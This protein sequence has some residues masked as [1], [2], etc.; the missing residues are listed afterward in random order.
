MGSQR[1]DA[2]N[3]LLWNDSFYVFENK[4]MGVFESRTSRL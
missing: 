3:E 2:E 4:G 1:M